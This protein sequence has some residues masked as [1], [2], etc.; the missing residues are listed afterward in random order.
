[1]LGERLTGKGFV[2]AAGVRWAVEHG[3]HVAN[4]SLSTGA[5]AHFGRFH[6][7]VDL[8]YFRRTML[9]SAIANVSGPSFP[10]EFAGVFSVAATEGT[11]PFRAGR[12]GSSRDR[13]GRRV[14]RRR[15]DPRDR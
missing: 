6:E 1:V 12:V 3:M 4:L 5:R 8:A 15:L 2:F 11:D 13:P 9:V 10:S 14:A 7:L